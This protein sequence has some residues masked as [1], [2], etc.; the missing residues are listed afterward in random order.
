MTTIS[1]C[2]HC[3]V[4]GRGGHGRTFQSSLKGSSGAVGMVT[5]AWQGLLAQEV[6]TCLPLPSFSRDQPYSSLLLPLPN[7]ALGLIWV[8]PG[9][10]DAPTP[11]SDQLSMWLDKGPWTVLR[12]TGHPGRA[13]E[14]TLWHLSPRAEA[15]AFLRPQGH[16]FMACAHSCSTLMAEAGRQPFI[17][18]RLHTQLQANLRYTVRYCP[19]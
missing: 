8:E 5:G 15:R 11:V 3:L 19:K 4:A 18:T 7:R 13:E 9:Q 17:Q 1:I 12:L 10:Q 6:C 14:Q 16:W 2:C